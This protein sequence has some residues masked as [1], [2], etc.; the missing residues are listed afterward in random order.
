MKRKTLPWI[1]VILWMAFIFFLSHQPATESS[2]LSSGITKKLY[3]MI[4]LV[5]PNISLDQ[6]TLN[7]VI[8]KFAHFGIY[9][10]LGLLVANGLMNI[11]IS[12]LNSILLALLICILY[13]ISDEIHQIFILGRS[14]QVSDVL[15][16][17]SGGLVGVLLLHAIRRRKSKECQNSC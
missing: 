11:N 9:L 4:K 14:G 7:H 5:A 1:P 13:A 15:I 12:R 10:I 6:G 3:D 2:E 16:D 8:R 17:S